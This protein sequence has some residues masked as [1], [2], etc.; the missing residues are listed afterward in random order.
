VAHVEVYLGVGH[1]FAVR[2][3]PSTVSARK[4]CAEDVLRF[5][6]GVCEKK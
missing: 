4:R 2:G 6:K 1:G 3:G 5:L